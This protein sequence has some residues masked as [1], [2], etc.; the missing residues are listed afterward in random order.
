MQSKI[1]ERENIFGSFFFN[2]SLFKKRLWSHV[3]EGL[4]KSPPSLAPRL[5][6]REGL[7]SCSDLVLR[8]LVA[9]VKDLVF[10]QRKKAITAPLGSELAVNRRTSQ[11]REILVAQLRNQVLF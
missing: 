7:C 4:V 5:M 8:K 9:Y 1:A 11:E 2:E 6:E 3:P 10:A